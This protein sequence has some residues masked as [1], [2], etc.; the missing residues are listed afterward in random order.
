MEENNLNSNQESS[1]IEETIKKNSYYITKSKK[2]IDFLI[3][4]FTAI[5]YFFLV[6]IAIG[7]ITNILVSMPVRFSGNLFGLLILILTLLG[8]LALVIYFMKFTRR[9]YIG[10]G[11]LGFAIFVLIAFGG[12][13]L[14][15][16][17]NLFRM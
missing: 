12:C 4:F 6:L 3:G 13:M 7:L 8:Y 10:I 11:L 16:V 14:V 15:I 2:V 1:V 5:L 9:K 17:P